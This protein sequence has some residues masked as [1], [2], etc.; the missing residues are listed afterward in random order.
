MY[1]A[2]VQGVGE[3]PKPYVNVNIIR[4]FGVRFT[5]WISGKKEKLPQLL[6]DLASNYPLYASE[7]FDSPPR[8]GARKEFQAVR[9]KFIPYH[10]SSLNGRQLNLNHLNV[11][12]LLA[13]IKK[14]QNKKD[15]LEILGVDRETAAKVMEQLKPIHDEVFLDCGEEDILFFNDIEKDKTYEKWSTNIQDL[16]KREMYM[17][18]KVRKNFVTAICVVDPLCPYCIDMLSQLVFFVEQ[19]FPLRLGVLPC[20]SLGDR[21]SRK[22]AFAFFH[23]AER[24]PADAINFLV[25][26]YQRAVA[27]GLDEPEERDWQESY[28]TFVADH[29]KW[30]DVHMFYDS[31]SP[32][33]CKLQKVN[34]RVRG[35]GLTRSSIVVNGRVFDVGGN[36]KEVIAFE[37]QHSFVA[38]VELIRDRKYESL[39]ELN[40]KELIGLERPMVKAVVSHVGDYSGSLEVTTKSLSAGLRIVKLLDEIEWTQSSADDPCLFYV[41]YSNNETELNAF[42]HFMLRDHIAP[43]E[44]A[45]NPPQKLVTQE[46]NKTIVI[47]S[48]RVYQG[49]DFTQ[50]GLYD[51]IELI[52][53]RSRIV[54]ENI[55][56]R[57]QR[58]LSCMAYEVDDVEKPLKL[59]KD[60]VTDSHLIY[61]SD[62]NADHTWD[63]IV[64]P[65]SQ[66]F[67][68]IADIIRYVDQ[69]GI[70]RLR[71]AIVPPEDGSSAASVM[72]SYYRCTL[73]Q[74]QAIFTMLNDTTQY[75][76]IPDMPGRW[77]V[78]PLKTNLDLDNIKL[79]NSSPGVY[80]ATYI[81]TD[82]IC[83]GSCTDENDKDPAGVKLAL[84]D[85]RGEQV[86]QTVVMRPSGYWQMF[87]RPGCWS[88]ELFGAQTKATYEMTT[89]HVIID[90]FASSHTELHVKMKSELLDEYETWDPS[91]VHVFSLAS[92]YAY[93]RF[94]RVM[95][96]SVTQHTES[97]VHFWLMSQF[98]SPPFKG[99]LPMLARKYNF[100]YDLI[101]YNWPFWLRKPVD[102]QKLVWANKILFLDAL[103]PLHLDRVIFVAPD[104][105]VRS[106]LM[107]LMELD[108]DEAPFRHVPICNSRKQ[109]DSR[110]F[111]RSNPW[112]EQLDG[113]WY[114][115]TSL[116]VIDLAAVRED[117]YGDTLRSY[118]KQITSDRLLQSTLDQDLVNYAQEKIPIYSLPQEWSWCETFCSDQTMDEAHTIS[119]CR[120]KLT[121]TPKMHLA[122]QIPEW[123]EIDAEVRDLLAQ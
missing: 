1:D 106:D 41:I 99:S 53:N 44:F 35:L 32:E 58:I 72:N 96:V 85:S 27:D 79:E 16:F 115:S 94:L 46:D 20:F 40:I 45:I 28:A 60:N 108:L 48:G 116:M 103:F 82:L 22:V 3:N 26:A 61:I 23:I 69:L 21:L 64:D 2:T 43:S 122:K 105:L 39:E 37:V 57:A 119:F 65:F 91:K 6:R 24:S 109:A 97:G 101:A 13:Q 34:Q 33:F 68:R 76:I 18:P 104:V 102:K 49:F 63:L 112:K 19:D 77:A 31:S 88:V 121:K 7:I 92:G 4:D 98:L 111:C 113:N 9:N 93:E 95:M 52:S 90:S 84:Y 38:L 100:T 51:L 47:A 17:L 71:M 83:E 56:R 66:Q 89:E 118:Y 123:V 86:D 5:S 110:R 67:Q 12:N 8:E 29:D 87:A 54:R 107:E 75:T 80:R 120:N 42:R 15:L 55:P 70:V 117:G 73:D 25:R 74:D 10:Y 114:H 81:L 14:D 36:S 50:D 78:E 59:W 11:F 30:S 62:N